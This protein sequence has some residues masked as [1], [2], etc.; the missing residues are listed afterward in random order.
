MQLMAAHDYPAMMTARNAFERVWNNADG[1][2]YSLPYAEFADHNVGRY[3]LYRMME[4]T[5]LSTF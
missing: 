1:I 3:V 4:A 2:E 5:G